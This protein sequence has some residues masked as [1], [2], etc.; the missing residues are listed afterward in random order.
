MNDLS[1]TPPVSSTMQAVI[2]VAD[3][4]EPDGVLLE[5]PLDLL[6]QALATSA[7]PMTATVMP[8]RIGR[9]VI[10]P[11]IVPGPAWRRRRLLPL[12][13]SAALD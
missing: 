5:P 7:M 8:V 9:K 1:S 3:A 12:T 6:P 10:I 13:V 11:S 2:G 4:P